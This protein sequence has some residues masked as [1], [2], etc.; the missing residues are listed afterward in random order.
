MEYIQTIFDF[1][2]HIDEHLVRLTEQYGAW[3]YAILFL[4][5]FVETGVVIWPWLPGDSLLFA[6]GALAGIGSLNMMYLIPLLFVAAVL[7]DT[8][9]Y[10]IGKYFGN[11]ILGLKFRGKQIIK[12]EHLDKTHTFY[13]K[14]GPRTI[15]L[16][17]FVPIVRTIAPF[18][19]GM[20]KMN[21]GKFIT[22]NLVGGAVW[23]API[24]TLG[25]F[26]GQ[27]EFVKHN[28]EYVV[29]GIIFISVIPIFV[30]LFKARK[31]SK[32]KPGA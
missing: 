24:L 6:A 14:H 23:V 10:L 31:K 25:Y 1:I 7:G 4:I 21:Y 5:I 3:I 27:N 20:G 2:L 32:I 22:Y 26:L 12:Q 8:C 11:H 18:V 30:E 9:N 13:E 29:L 28:F 16:A 19:A 15:I 17:R